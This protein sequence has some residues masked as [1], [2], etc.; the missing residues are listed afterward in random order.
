MRGIRLLLLA[1][2]AALAVGVLPAAA[3][4]EWGTWTHSGG[5]TT[6]SG[7]FSSPQVVTG[8]VVGRRARP[9]KNPVV[10]FT[11]GGH[12]CKLSSQLGTGYCYYVSI[13]KNTQLTWKLQ[14]KKPVR[15]WTSIAPCIEVS[16]RFHCRYGDN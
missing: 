6:W 12:T 4:P 5:G 10:S 1:G 16:G 3:G 9:A 8:F 13:P 7:T 14:F 11:I 2:F 15:W